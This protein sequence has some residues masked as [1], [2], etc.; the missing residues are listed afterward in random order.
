MLRELLIRAGDKLSKRVI[1]IPAAKF[2]HRGRDHLM[3]LGRFSDHGAVG[4]W[5][6][7]VGK[8]LPQV[9]R[10]YLPG[11]GFYDDE[12]LPVHAPTIRS[13]FTNAEIVA[14]VDDVLGGIPSL[15]RQEAKE[16]RAFREAAA[17]FG[18]GS[19]SRTDQASPTLIDVR[20][21]L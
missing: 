2:S 17:V 3:I 11:V 6:V 16:L 4:N 15:T 20:A 10:S 21:R 13:Q 12:K 19:P 8:V 18:Y 14:F 7:S 5:T 1:V 9:P